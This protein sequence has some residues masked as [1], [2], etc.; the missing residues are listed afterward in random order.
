[1]AEAKTRKNAFFAWILYE[2]CL[3]TSPPPDEVEAE[4][5]RIPEGC[6][7]VADGR[8]RGTRENDHR[9]AD[10]IPLHPGGI[11]PGC[12]SSRL[13]SGG[14]SSKRRGMTTG[15]LLPTLRSCEKIAVWWVLSRCDKTSTR[16][17]CNHGDTKRYCYKSYRAAEVRRYWS[18][19]D[20]FYLTG[21]PPIFSQLLR[22][23]EIRS[24]LAP[25]M[26]CD[27]I[28]IVPSR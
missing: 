11:P 6:K 5:V 4:R 27:P 22:V 9:I 26:D 18:Q 20:Q 15:Y 10:E 23:G 13:C 21:A 19:R 1:M 3:R 7:M 17:A 25:E 2:R 14:H 28:V 8:F 16:S 24:L 12:I